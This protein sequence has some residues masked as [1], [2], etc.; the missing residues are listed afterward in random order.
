MINKMKVSF[1]PG[2]ISEQVH[3][4]SDH[5]PPE[6]RRHS[7]GLGNGKRDLETMFSLFLFWSFCGKEARYSKIAQVRPISFVPLM[8]FSSNQ[9]RRNRDLV[10]LPFVL[11]L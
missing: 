1:H 4:C 8:C 9:A 5:L 6:D 10:V 2:R 3:W 7:L 11:I